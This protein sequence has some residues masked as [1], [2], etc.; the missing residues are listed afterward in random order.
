[1]ITILALCSGACIKFHNC[2]HDGKQIMQNTIATMHFNAVG[3][4]D[5]SFAL[6]S[7]ACIKFHNCNHD[8][9][10]IMHNANVTMHC[11]AVGLDD[12][13]FSTL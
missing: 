9:R 11:G 2:N 5:N 13:P 3:R 6:C 10:Q 8:G 4:D 12:N 1:M 7:G